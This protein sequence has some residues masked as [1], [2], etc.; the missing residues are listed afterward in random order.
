MQGVIGDTFHYQGTSMSAK[1]SDDPTKML[2]APSFSDLVYPVFPDST[3][4]LPS[5]FEAQSM[6]FPAAF[7]HETILMRKAA[8]EKL[9][10]ASSGT[11]TS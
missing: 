1:T 4:E 3:Y 9:L 8:A 2:V 7:I 11:T 5:L 6:T 10:P